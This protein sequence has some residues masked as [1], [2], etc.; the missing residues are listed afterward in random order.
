M[1]FALHKE[2]QTGYMFV[3]SVK[4][5]AVCFGEMCLRVKG[6]CEE[7]RCWV[8]PGMFIQF[9]GQQVTCVMALFT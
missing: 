3:F 2:Y 1:S 5:V 9:I 8:L 6:Q 7:S 4:P